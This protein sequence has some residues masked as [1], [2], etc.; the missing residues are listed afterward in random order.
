MKVLKKVGRGV[1][2]ALTTPA[3]VKEERSLAAQIV[4]AA[5]LS[6]GASYGVVE[7]AQKLIGG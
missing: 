6:A 2:A 5:L 3:A 1:L 4:T 7:I